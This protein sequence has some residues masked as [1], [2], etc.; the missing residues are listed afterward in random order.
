MGMES[1]FWYPFPGYHLLAFDAPLCIEVEL[2]LPGAGAELLPS[3]SF[4]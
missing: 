4:A 3:Q 2:I 1:D